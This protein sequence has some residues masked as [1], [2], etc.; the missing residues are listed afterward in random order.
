MQNGYIDGDCLQ[1]RGVWINTGAATG[2]P[3]VIR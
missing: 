3:F 1:V 2:D